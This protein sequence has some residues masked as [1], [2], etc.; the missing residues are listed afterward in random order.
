MDSFR[1]EA[2]DARVHELMKQWHVPGL[3]IAVLDHEDTEFKSFG[4]TSLNRD[5]LSS[6]HAIYDCAS[7]SKS[8]VAATIAMLVHDKENYPQI[9]WDTPVSKLLPDEFVLS[10][11][12]A[13]ENA[14]IEDLLCHRTGLPR[15]DASYVG[16]RAKQP[17]TPESMTKSLRYLPMTNTVGK[18]FSYNNIMYTVATY[19]VERLTGQSWAQ[20]LQDRI[21][22]PLEMSSSYLQPGAVLSSKNSDNLAWPLVWL[23]DKN[24]HKQ[25]GVYDQPEG[26]G[27]GSIHSTVVDY[28]KWIRAFMKKDEILFPDNIYD[29][30]TRPRVIADID[31][32]PFTSTSTYAL[33]WEVESYRGYKIVQHSGGVSGYNSQMLF[34][35]DLQFGL[36]MFGNE[37]NA[38]SAITVLQ[39]ELIDELLGIPKQNRVDWNQREEEMEK[40]YEQENKQ[41]AEEILNDIQDKF[42]STESKTSRDLNSYCGT[43]H[44][45]AYHDLIVTIKDDKL[46]VDGNDR[47]YPFQLSFQHICGNRF[48]VHHFDEDDEITRYARAYFGVDGNDS[49]NSMGISLED[50]MGDDLI[51]FDRLATSA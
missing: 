6:P 14:T 15:H 29:E 23:S 35:P 13:S 2:F 28:A 26:Q 7:T 5:K 11:P 27:A 42:G 17:D 50:N 40:K 39:M 3:S 41:S 32:I 45:G 44:H 18:K 20:F 33:G 16:I 24:T 48:L 49:V 30:L 46:H 19:V 38:S 25:I 1:S 51:W 9:D 31:P 47:T 4:F 8:F 12:Y 37:S 34:M 21:F 36:V 43:Y 22:D 10:D